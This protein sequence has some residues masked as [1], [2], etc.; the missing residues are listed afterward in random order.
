MN[1]KK[2][3]ISI[4]TLAVLS[5]IGFKVYK[6]FQ[7][8]PPKEETN[9]LKQKD[10][11]FVRPITE[12]REGNS[13]K[14]KAFQPSLHEGVAAFIGSYRLELAVF[15]VSAEK[16]TYGVYIDNSQ[17]QPITPKQ[18]EI[19]IKIDDKLL[20][21]NAIK[22]GLFVTSGPLPKLPTKV[23]VVGKFNNKKFSVN[24]DIKEFRTKKITPLID[25]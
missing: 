3:I 11:Y 8:S 17:S 13:L 20:K 22:N 24:F 5:F 2:L 15:G 9:I 14:D 7:K 10:S 6:Y 1:L 18:T 21:M 12:K 16:A 23:L 19:F 4:L 25:E